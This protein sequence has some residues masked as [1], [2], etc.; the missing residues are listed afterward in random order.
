MS[1]KED[2]VNLIIT[3]NGDKARKELSDL[4]KEARLLK[5]DMKGLNK[6]SQEYAD[7]SKRLKEV[8]GRMKELRTEIGLSA[9][10]MKELNQEL[11]SLMMVRQHLAPGTE[12]FKQ[13]EMAIR[14][15]KGR[16]TE[17]N[18]GI[19]ETGGV[20]NAIK[21]EIR[22]FGMIAAS[23]LGFQFLSQQITGIISKA[24]KLSD[25]LADIAKT[26]QMSTKEVEALNRELSKID[27]RTST[28]ELRDIAIVAGQLGIAKQ[29][30]KG[31]TESIDKANVALGDEFKDGAQQVA[32]ELG[33]LRNVF[34]DVKT[35][36]VDQD[37]LRI[38]NA[39]NEL[40]AA[41]VATGP[42]VADFAN[43]IGGVG[44]SLGLS[45]AQVLGLSATLQELNVNTERGGTAVVRILQKMT[46]DT[47]TFAKVAGMS[48]KDFSNLIN[49]D[50]FG[51]F[52]KVAQSVNSG[53]QSA[54]L[55]SG[56]LKELGVEGIGASEVLSKL[57]SNMPMLQEK[58]DLAGKSITNTASIMKEFEIKNSTL[59][60]EL[61]KLGKKFFAMATSSAVK[62]FLAGAVEK[63][64]AFI[65]WLS[66]LP[67]LLSDNARGIRLMVEAFIAYN[68]ALIMAT[69]S[70]ITNTT[71]ELAKKAAYEIGFKWTL[72]QEAATKAYAFATSDLTLR[73]KIATIA[74]R[75]WNAI[76]ALN[77]V[78]LV[79]GSMVA[80]IEVFD[81]YRRNTT[82][83]IALEKS[84]L[85][86]SKEL[87]EAQKALTGSTQDFA[88]QI[89]N[90]NQ[91]TPIQRAELQKVIE[92]K[93]NDA[94]ASLIQ[95]QAQQ[96]QIRV[97]ATQVGTWEAVW[98]ML[99][100]SGDLAGLAVDNATDAM[101]NG[102]DAAEKYNDP[103]QN[104]KKSIEALADQSGK[105]TEVN[106][107]FDRAMNIN[108]QTTEQYNEKLRLLRLALNN[109]VV[110]SAD[111]LKISNEIK[112]VQKDLAGKG[113]S[114][115]DD[116]AIDKSI[117]K[118]KE[119]QNQLKKIEFDLLQDTRGKFE[120]DV[121]A[122]N[123]KYDELLAKA[124]GHAD[125]IKKINTLRNQDLQNLEA[126]FNLEIEE[127]NHQ[128]SFS[129]LSKEDQEIEAIRTK[130][131]KKIDDYVGFNDKIKEL[132]A[133]RDQ[134]IADKQLQQ[135]AK[136][137]LDKAAFE[138][139][140]Y[141]MTLN[142]DDR[143]VV[144]A[145]NHYDDLITMADQFGLDSAGLVT[146]KGNAIEAIVERQ[147][148]DEKKNKAKHDKEIIE[149][150]RRKWAAIAAVNDAFLFAI[151]GMFRA[152]GTK[153]VIMLQFE[154]MVAFSQIAIDT[155]AA[156]SSAIKNATK[157]SVTTY[158]MI[159]NI[160][161]G[162]GAVMNAIVTAKSILSSADIPSAPA[163]KSGGTLP[164]GTVL[165][166]PQ[167]SDDNLMVVDPKTGKVIAK[168]KSGEPVLSTETYANNKEV[169][170]ALLDASMNKRGARVPGLNSGGLIDM[171]LTVPLQPNMASALRALRI[172]KFG[173]DN[174]GSSAS[175][176]V[177][178]SAGAN[179]QEAAIQSLLQQHKADMREMM[180]IHQQSIAE[181]EVKGVWDW[182]YFKKSNKRIEDIES[183][184]RIG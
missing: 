181:M 119:L 24:G 7:K 21:G 171:P 167:V 112:N 73:V 62:D 142:N 97:S 12:A 148:L 152:F 95:M 122:I 141:L 82:E 45:S 11:R 13:N 136:R 39:L 5:E 65:S 103:I 34:T 52:Q 169:V 96:E 18:S 30:V 4:D 72:L 17:L 108:A 60:A 29:E 140:I 54:T 164:G 36:A 137:Q 124:K 19:K 26:T 98:N 70:S 81:L 53:G 163:L 46:T 31:F 94:K 166:G 182:D 120:R 127:L 41:G 28:T 117:E 56:I 150:E 168:V 155:A 144:D 66:K 162:V 48:T 84:K 47:D 10:T 160:A 143:E 69:A 22:Q 63:V 114:P 101:K 105:I 154:K 78:G 161:M 109:A 68:G 6:E 1:V 139:Q 145:A 40:G 113:G 115:V 50:L 135:E 126:K 49:T 8:E 146:M 153:Q 165:P 179:G 9:K 110:G 132:E 75:A 55:F 178:N 16:I 151:T 118:L 71:V 43:R 170:D 107:A 86:L 3:I 116:E 2:K 59:G 175:R 125:E 92:A 42:V 106:T 180:L 38:G 44:I 64:S 87:D 76:L 156:V 184:S 102:K 159:L 157:K 79:L 23:Y 80:L 173:F 67:Q 176:T 131:Q 158:D 61:D 183:S 15:V 89:E 93:L 77:P 174:G 177:V 172:D 133:L 134:E 91:L 32:T 138:D 85:Q 121:A 37:I 33:K 100:N 14:A 58:V 51:A 147:R 20:L 111:F 35:D 99:K 57:A 104:L 88:T 83:A 149:S 25:Q 128:R 130:Y 27:T 90:L 123:N 74:Q 129:R